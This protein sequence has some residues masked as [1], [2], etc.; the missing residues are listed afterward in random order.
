LNDVIDN[1]FGKWGN[2]SKR[3]KKHIN[4]RIDS[5]ANDYDKKAPVCNLILRAGDDERY[6]VDDPCRAS[7]QLT[8]NLI[9]WAAQYN[10]NCIEGKEDKFFSKIEKQMQAIEKKLKK[11]HPD[12]E[13]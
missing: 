7:K 1:H 9:N 13:V 8:R 11:R 3:T 6:D 5:M 4:R 10:V 12:C 2:W